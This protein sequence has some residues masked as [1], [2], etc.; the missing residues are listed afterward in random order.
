MAK[1]HSKWA[2][3]KTSRAYKAEAKRLDLPCALCGHAIDYDA[4]MASPLSFT[5]D[6]IVELQDGGDLIPE[7]G[8]L[9][10]AHRKCNARRGRGVE[11]I[12]PTSRR[13]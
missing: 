8:G 12:E 6:H 13:W 4:P 5:T 9:R 7:P 11:F 10:P 2:W 1:P 3:T